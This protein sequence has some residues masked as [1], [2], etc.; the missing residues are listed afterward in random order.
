MQAYALVW[1]HCHLSHGRESAQADAFKIKCTQ[2]YEDTGLGML[3]CLLDSE[4]QLQSDV[5]ET[6]K[7]S[8]SN[9]IQACPFAG[10]SHGV[11]M[12]YTFL[13]RH[14]ENEHNEA[15]NCKC[16]IKQWVWLYMTKAVMV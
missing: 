2:P 14:E 13:L 16:N 1:L 12:K 7:Y 9:E 11:Q 4:D 8:S 15:H 5:Y 10:L 3:I 6:Y